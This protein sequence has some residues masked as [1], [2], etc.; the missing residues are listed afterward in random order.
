M[1][2]GNTPEYK[3]EWYLK[4]KE[5]ILA[6]RK[7]AYEADKEGHNAK[8]EAYRKTEKGKETRQRERAKYQ[9][10]DNVKAARA[11]RQRL[12]TALKLKSAILIGDEWNDFVIEEM[13][14]LAKLREK[15]TKVKWHVDHIV[16]LKGR[17]VCGMHV[18]YNLRVITASENLIKSN[19][20]SEVA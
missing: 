9:S 19:K 18:W 4:N 1:Y 8:V 15:E 20:M 11:S 14:Q 5:R 10:K 12:R 17:G 16:P 3:R 2:Y 13:Y 7:A 6:K